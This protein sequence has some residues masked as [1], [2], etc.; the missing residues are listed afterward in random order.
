MNEQIKR[1]IIWLGCGNF[2]RGLKILRARIAPHTCR[3]V[4]GQGVCRGDGPLPR[5]YDMERV[6]A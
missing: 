4:E 2:E 5:N 1:F 3:G 6:R